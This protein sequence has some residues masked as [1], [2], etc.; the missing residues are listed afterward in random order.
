MTTNTAVISKE[1]LFPLLLSIKQRDL[2]VYASLLYWL[3][4]RAGELLPYQHYKT[5]YK[6][7]EKGELI[8]DDRGFC[9]I[10]SREEIYSSPGIPV[11]SI[12]VKENMILFSAI[13]IF[14]SKKKG[15]TKIG[16]VPKKNNP[17]FGDIASY[18]SERKELQARR[19]SEA[20]NSGSPPSTVYLF[21]T[22]LLDDTPEL[23]FWRFKKRLDRVLSKKGFSPHSLRKTRLTHIGQK[24]G[25]VFYVKALSGHA[26]ISMASEYVASKNLL[27]DMKKYGEV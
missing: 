1:D 18:I 17:L 11:S 10:E 14:K 27:D 24:S 16:I 2:R 12:E 6:R 5:T 22:E 9:E 7:N 3:A 23:F 25:N 4:C 21:Q 20:E 13:P 26:S 15:E 19:N 8:R